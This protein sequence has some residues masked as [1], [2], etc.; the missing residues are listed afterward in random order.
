MAAA[1]DAVGVDG[2]DESPAATLNAL[3]SRGGTVSSATLDGSAR[4]RL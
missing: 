2:A 1:M 3:A 4:A